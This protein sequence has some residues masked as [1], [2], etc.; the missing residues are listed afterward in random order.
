MSIKALL[1]PKSPEKLCPSLTRIRASWAGSLEFHAPC[2]KEACLPLNCDYSKTKTGLFIPTGDEK[3]SPNT[4]CQQSPHGEWR[5]H[6]HSEVKGCPF[7]WKDVK[8]GLVESQNF[9]TT[10]QKWGWLLTSWPNGISNNYLGSTPAISQ[11][12]IHEVLTESW[13][14]HL[15]PIVTRSPRFLLVTQKLNGNLDFYSY[16]AVTRQLL[17]P[18]LPEQCWR[19]PAQMK[20][21]RTSRD[22]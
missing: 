2:Y 13:K 11:G 9:T 1:Q 5:L 18:P 19:K 10:K 21:K 12:S 4:H 20:V 3:A 17:S 22:S 14:L 6:I 15:H 8:G 7:Y 16:V